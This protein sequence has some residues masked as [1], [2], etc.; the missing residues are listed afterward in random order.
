MSMLEG[1]HALEKRQDIVEDMTKVMLP[2]RTIDYPSTR[3]DRIFVNGITASRWSTYRSA[4]IDWLTSRPD[5]L[6]IELLRF[7]DESLNEKFAL[8]KS[9]I[10]NRLK[11][12]RSEDVRVAFRYFVLGTKV[13]TRVSGESIL[14]ITR[15]EL[16]QLY[17]LAYAHQHIVWRDQL[18]PSG[19]THDN[20]M[21]LFENIERLM[22]KKPERI[23][24]LMNKR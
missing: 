4:I 8:E 3:L 10:K 19:K 21:G 20:V 5:P 9:V 24:P 17:I 1:E 13:G 2:R 7:D 23:E 16:L 22:R 15:R 18:I 11:I 12:R 14:A 6:M